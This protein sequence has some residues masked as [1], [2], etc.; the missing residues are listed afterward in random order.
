MA[1]LAT[2]YDR[3]FH[4]RTMPQA[5][6]SAVRGGTDDLYRLRAIPNEDIYFWVKPVDNSGVMAQADPQSVGAC[7]RFIGASLL[8]VLLLVGMLVP[9]AYNLLAGYQVHT[10]ERQR[11]KLLRERAELEL[12]E[13]QLLSPERLAELA[14]IQQFVDP[15]PASVV[16]LSPQAD[17]SLAMNR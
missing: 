11:E 12:E 15:A 16:Q 6:D 13:A 9:A 8:A 2:W 1:T 3:I 5:T 4:A 17:G 10:L 7:W 14:R